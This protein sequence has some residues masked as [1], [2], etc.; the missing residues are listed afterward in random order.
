MDE[1]TPGM[2]WRD[3]LAAAAEKSV[4]GSSSERTC[5]FALLLLALVLRFWGFPCIPYT[6]DEISALVRVDYPTLHEAISKGIWNID[7][8]PPATHTFLWVWTQLFGFGDGVVKAPF[9][10]MSVLA[11]FFLYRFTYAWTGGPV[12][13]I[14][15]A[16]WACMQYMVM[17]GQFAR[18][19]A[20]GLFT[21][22]LMADQLT[23]YAG[24]RGIRA[25]IGFALGAILSAYTHHFAL[26]QAALIAGTGVFL[27]TAKR[28]RP[29][30]VTCALIVLAYLPNVPLF[31]SQLGMKGLDSWLTAPDTHWLPRYLWWIAHCSWIQA[32]LLGGL[33]TGS[34]LLRLRSGSTSLP[35]WSITLVWGALPLVI[36]YAYSVLRSP[37]LQYSVLIF[38]FP[39]VVIGLL[40][41][42]RTLPSR[43]AI[44]NC[45][46][47]ALSGTT[48]LV[49]TR[50]HM[51]I[52]GDSKYEAIMRGLLRAEEEGSIA[53]VDMP[54]EVLAF[55][56]KL[57][58]LRPS[59]APC[60]NLQDRP[61]EVLDSVLAI[62]TAPTIFYGQGPHAQPEN[63]G[64]INARYPFLVERHD[65]AEGQTF[66]F[67][68]R[69]PVE[70][71][72]DIHYSVLTTPE[73]IGGNCWRVDTDIPLVRDT[74]KSY[75][76]S[77]LRWD[78][79]G[80]EYG[81]LL[82]IPVE[83]DRFGGNDVV[84]CVV[85]AEHIDTTSELNIVVELRTGDSTLFYRST[86][87]TPRQAL[88][89]HGHLITALKCADLGS[90]LPGCTLR[91]YVWNPAGRK[92]WITSLRLRVREGD[93]VLY[94]YFEPITEPWRFR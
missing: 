31:L 94:G 93:P 67:A 4:P 54:T 13:L 28:I 34:F 82:E 80:R 45:S 72:N 52:F 81:A 23:R 77:P 37:V 39:Y 22:A 6:H 63:V 87:V 14:T 49:F 9:V 66:V 1:V 64:R 8:H 51:R 57:W 62:T 21:T 40:S 30:L 24:G 84:E 17:Y 10:L 59:Q 73:A 36:G 55:Y 56:R 26:M 58:C 46:L 71:L 86:R 5:L 83:D 2:T 65:L 33:L 12:A 48:T 41:G 53:V 75:M 42:L 20:M 25:L 44:I 89:G 70:A 27:V 92:V 74:V 43:V 11:L 32:F 29:Y 79:S 85:D 18:P 47:I 38:S 15:T 88:Q 61:A 19:Y 68:A 69:P 78:L 91:T 35:L 3:R 50:Q 90:I 76:P 16:C 7:T 60:I